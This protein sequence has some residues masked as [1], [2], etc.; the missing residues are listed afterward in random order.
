M[1][2]LTKKSLLEQMQINELEI[3]R[4]K[5]LLDFTRTEEKLLAQAQ[6][7]IMRE[8]DNIVDE[9]Y[10]K[11]TSIE[12]VALTIGDS[13]TLQRL[14]SS[15]KKYVSELF[16]GYYD[17]TYVN[18]RLRIGLVHKRIGV[19]PKYYLSA[20]KILKETLERTI[21]ANITDES[22][23]VATLVALDKIFF[24]DITLVFDTYI[25][26]LVGEIE[27]SRDK[28]LRYASLLEQ[29]VAER[30]R[31]LE[32]LNRFDNLTSLLNRAA[33]FEE[34]RKELLR[35]KRHSSDLALIYMDINDF[36]KVN[37]TQGHAK[38]DE[39]LK[40]IGQLIQNIKREIDIAAR[41]G[42]DEFCVVLSQ[43]NSEE[44]EGFCQ[45]L[46][47]KLKEVYSD[48]TISIG[49]SQVDI[50]QY[51]QPDILLQKADQRMY[52]AKKAYHRRNSFRK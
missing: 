15:Q 45:R 27:I 31:E 9:F 13:E 29:K 30:T 44:A 2:N 19:E 11:E 25:R 8:I 51:D 48:V 21:R 40:T 42:G 20:V 35:A 16:S 3:L 5:E 23:L 33:F 36:K 10:R 37:D 24:F 18:N 47:T 22:V 43:S 34:F 4:R 49:I 17:E 1:T 6:S 26:S 46:T 41:L 12:E 52:E 38:G 32:Q 7:F 28:A 14:R 50:D 39:V